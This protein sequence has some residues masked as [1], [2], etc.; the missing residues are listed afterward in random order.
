MV[1]L[2]LSCLSR[3]TQWHLSHPFVFISSYIFGMD[4]SAPQ[5]TCAQ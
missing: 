5:D 2:I 4:A 3:V 1:L